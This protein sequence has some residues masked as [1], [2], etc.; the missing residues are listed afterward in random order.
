V[1]KAFEDSEL[2]RKVAAER[3]TPIEWWLLDESW[4]WHLFVSSLAQIKPVVP[5]FHH[6]I[7]N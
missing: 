7:H 4:D 6:L 5:H 1:E 3:K 2:A